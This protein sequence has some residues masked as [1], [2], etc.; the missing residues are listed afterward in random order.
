MIVKQIN[1]TKENN[2]EEFYKKEIIKN[3]KI[4]FDFF[5]DS[6]L[7][8]SVHLKGLEEQNDIEKILF[9]VEK[10][11][12]SKGISKSQLRSGQTLYSINIFNNFNLKIYYF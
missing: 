2:L 9:I 4:N 8:A 5:M 3:L 1:A 6:I 12:F 11:A 10:M 7:L